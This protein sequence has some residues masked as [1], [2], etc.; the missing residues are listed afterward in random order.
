MSCLSP[1]PRPIYP[2]DPGTD[3]ATAEVREYAR[4]APQLDFTQALARTAQDDARLA[5]SAVHHAWLPRKL[6][7]N[8]DPDR[9]VMHC[10]MPHTPI[11]PETDQ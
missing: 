11:A 4:R 10:L 7:I 8:P 1:M 3:L 2:I 5:P 6:A 9:A